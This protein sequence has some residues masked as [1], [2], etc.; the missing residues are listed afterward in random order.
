MSLLWDSFGEATP[1]G[2]PASLVGPERL[3]AGALWYAEAGLP[4]FPLAPR[5][6]IPH[7]GSR[8]CRDATSD[9]VAVRRAWERAPGS[10]IGLATGH[11]LDAIDFDG[12]QAHAAWV[13]AHPGADTWE[14]CSVEVLAVVST[15]RAGGLH[16]YVPSTGRGNRAGL[17][18]H[19]DYRGLGGYV[20][21]APSVLPVGTYRFI[22]PLVPA[23]LP[24]D[25]ARMADFEARFWPPPVDLGP[26]PVGLGAAPGSAPAYVR[27]AYR[28]ELDDLAAAPEGQRNDQLNR[29]A[30]NLAQLVASGHLP[31]EET[32][33]DLY[34]VA[35]SIGL[36][37]AETRATLASAFDA[38]EKHPRTVP[39]PAALAVPEVTILDRPDPDLIEPE[40]AAAAAAA[41][42]ATYPLVDWMEL[43]ADE[44]TEEWI[45]EPI[46]P[47]RRL[48]A[49][50]SPPKIGKSLLMLELAVAVSR[51]DEVL[52]WTPDRPRRVLYV[53]FENDPRGD[54]RSRL[55]AMGRKP[56]ELSDLLYLSFPRLPY[57][58]TAVG[59]ATLLA[60]VDHYGAEVVV[61]DTISRAVGGEEND[62]DTWLSFYRHTGVALKARGVACIRLDHTGKDAT[63]GMRGGSAKYGDVDVVWSLTDLGSSRLQLDCTANRLPVPEKTLIVHR[64]A[65]PW[66]RHTVDPD[67]RRAAFA[68]EE[69]RV[70]ALLDALKKPDDVEPIGVNEAVRRLKAAGSGKGR[71]F[72]SELLQ[73][74][75]GRAG[76]WSQPGLDEDDREGDR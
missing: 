14:E 17:L 25:V 3:L 7:E 31:R 67:G 69:R 48:V 50:F 73:K 43:W 30:F 37:P 6:K 59:G 63:K 9:P 5:S 53:D 52:G 64:V 40:A 32:L 51:G 62:N 28:A 56:E 45:V 72:V 60:V 44:S 13:S 34:E 29:A 39:D 42:E 57:L 70:L 68:E 65:D 55:Q 33:A 11:G 41:I 4:V 66:L 46:L 19:V 24:G 12:F 36:T 76:I 71:K 1:D 54:V 27:A 8:G 75:A 58:D 49:L 15:P 38:G 47:A 20:V 16:I 26:R 22:E 18:D 2:P 61:I 21:A 10:N 23:R 35:V 74:R